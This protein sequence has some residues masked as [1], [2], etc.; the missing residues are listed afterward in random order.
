MHIPDMPPGYDPFPPRFEDN[1]AQPGCARADERSAHRR[2]GLVAVA[3]GAG[4]A[5]VFRSLGTHIVVAGGQTM[6]PSTQ[7]LLDAIRK[8]PCLEVIILPNNGNVLMAAQQ[9]QAVAE[10]E[11]KKVRV[12]PS[13][14]IPQGI[15]AL[16]ALNV[17]ATW[18]G[19]PG[20]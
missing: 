6:N 7:D 13:K 16:L 9:A 14:T 11:G 8:L 19:T 12:V 2:P 17:H 4:L 1:A 18:S 15:S 5:E 20:R 3:P 10:D